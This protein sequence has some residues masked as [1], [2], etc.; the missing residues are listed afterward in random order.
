MPIEIKNAKVND[1]EMRY[2]SF[3]SGPKTMVI[4]PGLDVTSVTNVAGLVSNQY[5][6]FHEDYTVYVIDRRTNLPDP[7]SIEQM[8]DDTAKVLESI[9]LKDV[10]LYGVSQGGMI[11][12]MLAIK[13]PELVKKMVLSATTS[14]LTDET[15]K[16]VTRWVETAETRDMYALSDVLA[17]D[18]FSEAF[19]KRYGRLLFRET[20]RA[21]DEDI[22]RYLILAKTIGV[23]DIYDEL[24]KIKCDTLVIGAKADKVFEYHQFLDIAE[25]IGC[26]SLIYDGYSH[27][28]FDENPE[29]LVKIKEFFDR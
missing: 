13:Y 25:K 1:I 7:Y 27:C 19:A 24:D 28:V 11:S 22:D 3:G 26:E 4:I 9:E 14:R 15:V 23:F 29:V 16:V 21:T 17:E 12:Q 5:S 20:L 8:A 2:F 10:Y 18:L 6:D